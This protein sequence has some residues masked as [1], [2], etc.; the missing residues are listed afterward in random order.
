MLDREFFSDGDEDLITRNNSS[1]NN[2]GSSKL[3]LNRVGDGETNLFYLHESKPFR[4]PFNP[5]FLKSNNNFAELTDDW[6]SSRSTPI[7]QSHSASQDNRHHLKKVRFEEN[8]TPGVESSTQVENDDD[9]DDDEHELMIN[10]LELN[11][12][13][14]PNPLKLHNLNNHSISNASGSSSVSEGRRNVED[15]IRSA[16][17]VNHYIEK[18]MNNINT[19]RSALLNNE[20]LYKSTD[21]YDTPFN[22]SRPMS[23][24]TSDSCDAKLITN[25]MS[26]IAIQDHND[27]DHSSFEFETLPAKKQIPFVDDDYYKNRN[28]PIEEYTSLL[29][30]KEIDE[31]SFR[32]IPRIEY[33]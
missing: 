24:D 21:D 15:L 25:D 19:F 9:D 31:A 18:N 26:H 22:L 27:D 20:S 32:K 29:T 8:E 16:S 28:T 3:D 6:D 14:A 23:T 12:I 17:E 10:D 5:N 2:D 4:I 7:Y 11:G 30:P 1:N 33:G 13:I